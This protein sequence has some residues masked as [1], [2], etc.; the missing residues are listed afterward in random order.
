MLASPSFTP[1]WPAGHLPHKGG[2]YA[3]INA[4]H[5]SQMSQGKGGKS[6]QPISPLEG[7]MPG[8]AEGGVIAPTPVDQVAAA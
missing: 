2:D 3:F 5:Q 4:R 7:E 8:R 1:L 6:C